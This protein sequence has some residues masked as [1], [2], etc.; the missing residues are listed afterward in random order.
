MSKINFWNSV[1]KGAVKGWDMGREWDRQ[2]AE[3]ARK[4]DKGEYE[5]EQRSLAKKLVR[6]IMGMEEPA[7]PVEAVAAAPAEGAAPA[8]GADAGGV[9]DAQTA[10]LVQ[11][12]PSYSQALEQ[13]IAQAQAQAKAQAQATGQAAPIVAEQ[14][15][16]TQAPQPAPQAPQSVPQ[17]GQGVAALQSVMG[18][19]VQA[20]A[21]QAMQAAQAQP[22]PAVQAAQAQAQ[23][24]A[25]GQDVDFLRGLAGLSVLQG[26]LGQA[27]ALHG[28]AQQDKWD[29][30]DAAVVARMMNDPEGEEA[31]GLAGRIL[32][33]ALPGVRARK[34][35]KSGLTF[36]EVTGEDGEGARRV[37]LSGANLMH[38]ILA[39][40][41]MNRGQFDVALQHMGA[42]DKDVA[43][44]AGQVMQANINAAKMNNSAQ[45]LAFNQGMALQRDA[46]DAVN[47]RLRAAQLRQSIGQNAAMFGWKAEDRQQQ[48]ALEA[49]RR[50]YEAAQ[51]QAAGAPAETVAAIRA[52]IAQYKPQATGAGAGGGASAGGGGTWKTDQ[53]KIASFI[54]KRKLDARGR[55]EINPMNGEEVIEVTPEDMQGYLQFKVGRGFNS[56]DEALPKYM[57]ARAQMEAM[58]ADPRAIA[59][60]DDK[61]MTPEQKAEALRKLGYTDF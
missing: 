33:S 59:I 29:A 35:E 5:K 22:S 1:A 24:A 38:A 7:A 49:Q 34:D 30:E 20:Q 21:A 23:G 26:N 52:G 32:S 18:A 6:K 40:R 48:Q 12:A 53:K 8:A 41:A 42:V 15:P 2:N 16:M 45:Q 10:P 31:R 28:K 46:R 4:K 51:A 44:R 19:P 61:T 58:L 50:D 25:G 37:E 47:D 9:T 55:P 11:A 56:D 60:R 13:G 43:L 54:G 36:L 57:L 39:E 17:K 3:E 27:A 14:I